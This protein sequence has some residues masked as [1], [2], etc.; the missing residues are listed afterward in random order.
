MLADIDKAPQ[1]PPLHEL[2]ACRETNAAS[3]ANSPPLSSGLP[4]FR[5]C[6]IPHS[7]V[8]LSCTTVLC[9]VEEVHIAGTW[10]ECCGVGGGWC[11][12]VAQATLPWG[13]MQFCFADGSSQ[14]NGDGKGMRQMEG[15]LSNV[16]TW[17]VL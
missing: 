11:R 3:T 7:Q 15:G 2:L 13:F 6:G 5:Y 10:N 17:E 14:R 16:V 12:V 8:S 1:A 4:V 9:I